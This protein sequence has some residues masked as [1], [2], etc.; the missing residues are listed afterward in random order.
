MPG[1][2]V[3]VVMGEGGALVRMGH[4]HSW[5]DHPPEGPLSWDKTWDEQYFDTEALAENKEG[6]SEDYTL[7]ILYTLELDPNSRFDEQFWPEVVE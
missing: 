7:D 2:G 4:T 5:C 3:S 6:K 1:L